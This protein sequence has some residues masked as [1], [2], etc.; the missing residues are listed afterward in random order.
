MIA[1]LDFAPDSKPATQ[2][3]NERKFWFQFLMMKDSAKLTRYKFGVPQ[4]LTADIDL[5]LNS[6]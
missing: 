5:W 3:Q 6:V 2:I 4:A 1:K